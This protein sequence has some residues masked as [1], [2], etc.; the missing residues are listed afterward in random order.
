MINDIELVSQFVKRTY[1]FQED[2]GS[3]VFK[4]EINLRLPEKK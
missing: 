1:L 2:N 3:F 4:G